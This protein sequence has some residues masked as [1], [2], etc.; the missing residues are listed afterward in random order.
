MEHVGVG[1]D[2]WMILLF[3]WSKA[4]DTTQ[5]H[6]IYFS[7]WLCFFPLFLPVPLSH[8]CSARWQDARVHVRLR[9]VS[10]SELV[11]VFEDLFVSCKVCLLTRLIIKYMSI[12]VGGS[13]HHC[14]CMCVCGLTVCH[15]SPCLG[16]WHQFPPAVTS[17]R[18]WFSVSFGN[19]HT[20]PN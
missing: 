2:G 17:C 12:P 15:L 13:S 9:C 4:D 10:Q 1:T 11:R 18:S 20:S 19:T 8:S 14:V 5:C 7:L 16:T 3:P 6:F